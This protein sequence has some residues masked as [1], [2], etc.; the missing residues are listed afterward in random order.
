MRG[1]VLLGIAS[2]LAVMYLA[3]T[4]SGWRHRGCVLWVTAPLLAR[5]ISLPQGEHAGTA[6]STEDAT[7]LRLVARRTWRYFEQFV[8]AEDHF[9]P[10]DNFQ[11][12]P[13][14]ILAQRTSPTNIGM[15]LLS[16]VCAVDFG[17][18]GLLDWVERLEAT[19]EALDKLERHHGHFLN[20]YDTRTLL[21]LL[22]SY[23]STVDSGNLAG[24]LLALANAIESV[25]RRPLWGESASR[26]SWM[27]CSWR[28]R[29]ATR[30]ALEHAAASPP[31][32]PDEVPL[33]IRAIARA[34]AAEPPLSAA[35]PASAGTEPDWLQ[36]AIA[37]VDSHL[38]DLAGLG[39]EPANASSADTLQELAKSEPAG[40]AR[41]LAARLAQVAQAARR[42]AYEMD[43]T[44]LLKPHRMLLSIGFNVAE[45]RLDASDYDLLASEARLASFIAIAKRDVPA[46]HWFRLDRRSVALGD[47]TAL[48]SWSG[49]MFEYLMPTLVMRS[50]AGSLLDRAVKVAVSAQRDYA[51]A[52]SIPWGISESAFNTRDLDQTYQYS[53]FGIPALGLKRGLANDLVV[54]PYATG[55]AAMVDP[56]AAAANFR[57]LA[58][59]GGLG[60]FGF[61]EALDF[62]PERLADGEAVA[63]VRA[64]MSHHQGMIIV[65]IA[66][67]L[68]GG[69]VQ[70]YF[71]AEATTR[72]SELL[73]Q[74][75]PPRSVEDAPEALEA[76]AREVRFP[77][78]AGRRRLQTWRPRTPHTQL[79]S[80]GRYAVMVNANG[81]GFSRCANLAVTRWTEDVT[82]D[83]SGHAIFL[84]D[85]G[86]GEVWSA[87]LPR[88]ASS[89]IRTASPF[90]RTA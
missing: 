46:R 65:G 82:C 17:W 6:L 35:A 49:S 62:T 74:E 70:D 7:Y 63:I 24:H 13:L 69:A 39:A 83:R 1:G 21:P 2:A 54:A 38:R 59:A 78:S 48:L 88:R 76:E 47:R 3:P 4:T 15:Y 12:T 40:G 67:A 77:V 55:L 43:F 56:S 45:S 72:A 50:P 80:N 66:N 18:L 32:V 42:I 84:R 20:W 87:A 34:I 44:F 58:E 36:R 81:A 5:Q 16:S 10:P 28:R 11:E 61:Y 89:P 41:E 73:L 23:V 33:R 64:Y 9:L 29:A 30:S 26:G 68:T 90:P 57:L 52:R 75:K 53:P 86:S 31:S 25:I 60:R 85:R 19:L 37:C 71:H 27:R 51:G 8:T 22:P 14:P 79:L